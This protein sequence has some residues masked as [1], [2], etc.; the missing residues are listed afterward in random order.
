MEGD[1]MSAF[2]ICTQCGKDRISH[3]DPFIGHPFRGGYNEEDAVFLSRMKF[4]TPPAD[5]ALCEC[6]A[7]Y[8]EHVKI[9]SWRE[10]SYLRICP[11]SVFR[12]QQPSK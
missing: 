11:S 1:L 12:A 9:S 5:H 6:G 10:G 7:T 3:G 8:G 2:D 4:N